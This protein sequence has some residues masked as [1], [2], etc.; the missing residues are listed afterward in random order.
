MMPKAPL[1]K[2]SVYEVFISVKCVS[3]C[4]VSAECFGVCKVSMC[5]LSGHMVLV[6]GVSA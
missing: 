3:I 2:S 1:C 6:P 5:E 4:D